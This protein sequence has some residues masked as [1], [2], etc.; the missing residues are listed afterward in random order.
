MCQQEGAQAQEWRRTWK[1]KS[2]A[3]KRTYEKR[4]LKMHSV[5][6]SIVSDSLWPHQT[7]AHQIPLSLGFPRQEYWSELPFP[8]PGDPPDQGMELW[9]PP[10]LAESLLSEPSEKPRGAQGSLKPWD[11]FPPSCLPS[12]SLL[13]DFAV[14]LYENSLPILTGMS[15]RLNFSE[16]F[17]VVYQSSS[18]PLGSVAAEAQVMLWARQWATLANGYLAS[19]C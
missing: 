2:E 6:C 4:S 9:F 17:S 5:S 13:K 12:P 18:H 15:G 19:L 3:D 1:G 8:S 11:E 10:L 7:V 16:Q 14:C